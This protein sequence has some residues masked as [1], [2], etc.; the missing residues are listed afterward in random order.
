MSGYLAQNSVFCDNPHSDSGKGHTITATRPHKGLIVASAIWIICIAAALVAAVLRNTDIGALWPYAMVATFPALIG[1]A[2]WPFIRNEWAQII[3][4]LS[5]LALAIVGCLS[6][7]FYPMALLFMCAPA[8][9]ALFEK[10]KVIEAMFL[11][12]VFAAVIYYAGQTGF[13]DVDNIATDVQSDWGKQ[14]AIGATIAFLIAAM[15]GTADSARTARSGKSAKAN[16]GILNAIPGGILRVMPDNNVS[17]ATDA[18][19]DIFDY[20]E[21]GDIVPVTTIVDREADKKALLRLIDRVRGLRS[22]DTAH[23]QVEAKD[24]STQYLDVTASAL[25]DDVVLI[26]VQDVSAQETHLS[27]LNADREIA[28]RQSEDKALFF[29]GVS[30]ELRTPLNAIIGFSDMMRSRLFGPLPSKYAE[31]ADMIHDSGQHMLDLIGDVLDMTKVDVG[32][33]ELVYNT[34]DAADVIRSSVKMIQ[35]TADAAEVQLVLDFAEDAPELIIEADRKALRQMLLNLLS[36]AIKFSPKGGKVSLSAKTVAHVLNVTVTDHGSGM[37]EA[38]LEQVGKP[39]VQT[40]SGKNSDQR[41]S[42]LGLSLVK[43]LVELHN[44]RFAIAS[45]LD[46]GT[47]ADIYLPLTRDDD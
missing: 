30:H 11:S 20:P 13:M 32:K 28:D 21:D 14:A 41:G 17:F 38:E 35:P 26:H 6:I 2:M 9:A 5:W 36:N 33:Y 7:A 40:S 12:A 10:E 24:G 1:M 29:A 25:D 44:G 16:A 3:V 46:R 18:V 31:Y 39:F 37:S 34:F 22:S 45:Q 15:Y 43:S 42:G 4:I 23:F 19:R 47:T 27:A 8:A